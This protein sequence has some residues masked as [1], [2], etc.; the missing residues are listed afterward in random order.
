MAAPL[1]LTPAS[2][3]VGAEVDGVDL[4]SVDGEQRAA[5][6]D[7]WHRHGVLFFR[8]QHLDLAEQAAA[9]SIFGEPERFAFAPAVDEAEPYVHRI[10]V[11]AGRRFGGTS[12]WHSDATWLER[13]PR[14]SML[15]A[16]SLPEVGGD[17]LFASSA[18]AYRNLSAP[19]R[20]MVDDLTARH[21]GGAPLGRA[22]ARV[23]AVVPE[24]PVAHPVVRVHPVTGERCLFVNRLFTQHIDGLTRRESEVLLPMLCDQFTDPEIQCRFRWAPGD[25]AVWDNRSVQHYASPDYDEAREMHRVVLAGDPVDAFA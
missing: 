4:R 7:A 20:A 9:A 21:H 6:V 12:T 22:A 18:M 15:Q 19:V 3:S 25:V 8:G 11:D 5:L 16:V 24:E 13:P 1:R 2:G 23:G 10:A 17:T 14:G